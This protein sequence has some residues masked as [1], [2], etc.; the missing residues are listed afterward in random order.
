MK[1][2]SFSLAPKKLGYSG[3]LV[4]FEL[5]HRSIHKLTIISRDNSDYIKAKIKDLAL[6]SF[7]N[8][9]ANIPHPS[10]EEY[11][12]LKNLSANNLIIQKA[13][14]GTSVLLVEKSVY[15]RHVEKIYDD[16]TKLKSRKEF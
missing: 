12:R 9:N 16:A 5:F 15:I 3:Y 6:T 14:K 11:E 7:R 1:G 10:N 13:D 4:N 2:L 8:Y